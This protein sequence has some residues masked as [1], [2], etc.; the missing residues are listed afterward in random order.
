[1]KNGPFRFKFGEWVVPG[2]YIIK[3]TKNTKIP[4]NHCS[5]TIE[6]SKLTNRAENWQIDRFRYGDYENGQFQPTHPAK[7]L[8]SR[9]RAENW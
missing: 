9:D 3:I 1:L 8:K 6:N 7:N 5:K 2:T 4:G